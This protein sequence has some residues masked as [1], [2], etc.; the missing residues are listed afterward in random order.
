MHSFP[1][2]LAESATGIPIADASSPR[3]WFYPH[4]FNRFVC[5][6]EFGSWEIFIKLSIVSVLAALAYVCVSHE[7][8]RS[9]MEAA[10]QQR[11][12]DVLARPSVMWV[13]MGIV[14]LVFRTALWFRYRPFAPMTAQD[15]PSL[16]V[17]IPAYNEGA[18]VTQ[19]IKSVACADYPR[20][21][22][23]ILVVDDGST[24][25]TWQHIE[26][27]ARLYPNLVTPIRLD[28]NRG[29]RA[30]LAEGFRL[31]R[32]TLVVTIDSDSII[33][34]QTLLAIVAPF[35]DRCIGAVAGK[36]TVYN[37]RAGLI[38]KMLRV[39]FALSFDFLRAVQSTFGT[40]NC[41]PG[42]LSAYRTDVVRAVLDSWLSQSFLGAC[43][44]IGEDRALTNYIL[45]RGFNCVYQRTAVVRTVVPEQYSKLARMYLRWDRSYVREEF[46]FLRIVWKR[47]FGPA[48][49]AFIDQ[50][51]S[52]FR[53]PVAYASLVLLVRFSLQD[54]TSILRMLLAM[55]TMSAFYMLY[56][57]RSE[58]SWDFLYGIL[59]S[60]FYFFTLFWIFPYAV[61]TVR[62][63]GWL[64]R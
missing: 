6:V 8:F 27:G 18:M 36:V 49:I 62:S 20:H 52:N 22:L 53:Y 32:G 21:L 45:E 48:L 30:A 34:K 14:L 12:L 38:P 1:H 55:G 60:Y 41:C 35:Q 47:P 63:R 26:Y 16:T 25:D 54:P 28:R 42:A 61:L 7:L 64:T 19:S 40:V 3:P 44:T 46:R 23:Q 17:V 11:W 4:R 37:T 59:Y 9:I 39:R 13:T 50:V 29:K 31:A 51:F 2:L 15:A 33:E 5:D 10:G 56:F 57:L 24:D 43:C 58:W